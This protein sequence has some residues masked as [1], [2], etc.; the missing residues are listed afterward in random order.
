MRIAITGGTGFI[1]TH[2]GT[3]LASAGHEV[4]VLSRGARPAADR[5]VLTTDL[6]DA[7]FLRQAFADC[8]AVAHC[9]GIN[10]EIGAQTF[11]KVHVEATRNVVSA[12]LAA[13]VPKIVLT[14]N[15]ASG[16]GYYAMAGQGFDARGISLNANVGYNYNLGNRWF[17]EPSAGI[18]WSRTQVDQM[19]VPGTIVTGLGGVPP[20]VLTVKDIESTLGRLSVR[21]GTSSLY[22]DVMLQPFA[23]ASVFHEFQGGVSSSPLA[24]TGAV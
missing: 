23:S 7:E 16:A 13:R 21:V 9:A 22:G 24:T 14:V 17:V 19:N 18:I 2:L 20:W 10:R 4:V 11:Q 1:G 15:H 3:Q 12:A 8:D 5:G 6:S